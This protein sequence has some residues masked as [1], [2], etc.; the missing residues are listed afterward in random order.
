MK[1]A[2]IKDLKEAKQPTGELFR[3]SAQPRRLY[4]AEVT[5]TNDHRFCLMKRKRKANKLRMT[6]KGIPKR[7]IG[8]SRNYLD[9]MKL[10]HKTTADGKW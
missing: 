9:F 5:S 1:S 8:Y 2:K 7:G 6:K 10:V 4:L 3:A